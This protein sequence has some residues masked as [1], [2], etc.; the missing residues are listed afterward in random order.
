MSAAAGAIVGGD[1]A[2]TASSVNQTQNN[3]LTHIQEAA[4][5]KELSA[6]NTN[7]CRRAVLVKYIDI[8]KEQNEEFN[9]A[10]KGCRNANTDSCKTFDYLH[11]TQRRDL[12]AKAGQHLINDLKSGNLNNNWNQVS[13]DKN[14]FHN[15]GPD[16]KPRK[17]PNGQYQYKKFVSKDGR[18][19]VI[20]DSGKDGV[21]KPNEIKSSNIVTDPTNAGSYNYYAPNKLSHLTYDVSPYI[22]N[23]L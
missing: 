11:V 18:L 3:Y 7:E 2:G 6:C 9:A 16:G 19:E 8:D 1:T 5:A 10:Y 21:L 23:F 22:V 17:L 4:R 13:D 20:V 14:I 12:N 15:F